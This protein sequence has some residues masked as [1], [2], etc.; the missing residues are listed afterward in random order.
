M[1]SEEL[2]KSISVKNPA[3]M[4][5]LVIDGLGGLPLHGKTEL[6]Q[7]HIPYLD[8]LTSKSICGLVDPIAPGIT[9]GSGPSHLAL[10]G[11]DP[12]KYQIGRGVIEALGI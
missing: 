1:I 12:M 5:M 11:Y 7:S 4:I 2:M 9:P 3:K 10:F 8:K 6:E